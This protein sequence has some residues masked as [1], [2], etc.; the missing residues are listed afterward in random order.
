MTKEIKITLPKLGESIISATVVQWLK[1][2]GDRVEKDE[3]LLEVATDKVNSEIPSPVSGILKSILVKESQEVQV[4]D[5]L[6]IVL[7]EESVKKEFSPAVLHL[8]KEKGILMEDLEKISGT[9]EGGRVTKKDIDHFLEKTPEDKNSLKLSFLR[10]KIAENMLLSYKEIPQATLIDEIDVTEIVEFIEKKKESFLEKHGVKLSITSFIA[11]AIAKACVKHP[12][13]NS[14]FK[15]DSILLKKEVNLGF[16]V[17]VDDGV[18][19]PVI[20][21]CQE[22]NIV[23]IAKKIS[24][25]ADRARKNSLAKENVS[26]GSIT[27]SNFGMTKVLIGIPIIRYPECAI[28]GLG[29]IKKKPAVVD[30]K[31]VVRSIM[32]ITLT[33]DHRVFDGIYGCNFLNEIKN[34]L[35]HD[36]IAI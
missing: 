26:D 33:F 5:P 7:V 6:A 32:M 20:K 27:F 15:N 22:L 13:V 4:G 21:D 16:A 3:N 9:G 8:A 2:E 23:D 10:K 25:L 1:K 24:E 34:I 12:L 28:I 31:I 29:A 19:V 36:K 18:L 35:T 14:S 17:S 11:R 30:D